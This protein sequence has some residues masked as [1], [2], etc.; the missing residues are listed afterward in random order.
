MC[1]ISF[2]HRGLNLPAAVFIYLRASPDT[3][4]AFC[5]AENGRAEPDDIR[6]Y[7]RLDIPQLS[8]TICCGGRSDITGDVISP[9]NLFDPSSDKEPRRLLACGIS[10]TARLDNK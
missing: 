5:T 9:L 2:L 6:T 7:L 8:M 3:V 4:V 1:T 10:R